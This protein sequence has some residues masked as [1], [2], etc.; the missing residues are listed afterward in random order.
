M[1]GRTSVG[2]AG[3]GLTV[4]GGHD[5]KK[6]IKIGN[7]RKLRKFENSSA[8]LGHYVFKGENVV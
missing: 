2:A 7:Q 3:G 1:E 5:G 6:F 8:I 4:G